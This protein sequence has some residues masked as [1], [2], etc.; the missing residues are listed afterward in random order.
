MDSIFGFVNR[1]WDGIKRVFRDKAAADAEE[2][3]EIIARADA[4]AREMREAAEAA[5]A[6]K[7]LD[8][9][10]SSTPLVAAPTAPPA[11][12][13]TVAAPAAPAAAS[14]TLAAPAA[15]PVNAPPP[16]PASATPAQPAPRAVTVPPS[17]PANRPN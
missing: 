1:V 17:I 2:G 10:L 8:A 4:E 14:V 11:V 6:R 7:R 16:N 3:A 15:T 12:P 9:D 13:S 5:E